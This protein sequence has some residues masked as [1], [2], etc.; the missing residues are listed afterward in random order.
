[1]SEEIG[2]YTGKLLLEPLND[3][4]KMRTV[5]DFGFAETGGLHWPVPRG[6]TV[7]GA[8]IPW[9]LWTPF[10]GPYEGKYRNASVVHDYYCSVHTA[11][12][13]AVHL[14]F[15]RAML[16]SG[17]SVARAKV[18]YLAV[19]YFGPSW[20]E[21]DVENTKLGMPAIPRRPDH[22]DLM[23]YVLHDPLTIAV[24]NVIERGGKSA[25][26]WICTVPDRVDANSEIILRL[27]DLL[28]IVE[29]DDPPLSDLEAAVDR[30]I[31]FIPN[32]R[33][34]PRMVLPGQFPLD[35]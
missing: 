4:R 8:S 6:T 5:L 26:D 22:D 34:A 21:M 14:M 10:G 11:D 27:D 32:D 17:V 23:F 33:T 3:G 29:R 15:Y 2:H 35:E 9:L 13:Q 30:A 1:M 12:Y 7:D 31:D 16:V 24:S 19:K 20:S 18:M 25:H 28:E